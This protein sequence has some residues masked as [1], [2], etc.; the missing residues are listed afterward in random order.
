MLHTNV[1]GCN[2]ELVNQTGL[3]FKEIKYPQK[4]KDVLLFII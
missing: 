4:I 1:V 2:K 3:I